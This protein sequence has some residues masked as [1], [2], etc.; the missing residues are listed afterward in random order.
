M[1]AVSRPIGPEQTVLAQSLDQ[2][3]T[4]D[5]RRSAWPWVALL[6]AGVLYGSWIPFD[7]SLSRAGDALRH[8][9]PPLGF[10]RSSMDDVL[11]NIAVYVP[12]GIALF[13]AVGRRGRSA[14][15]RLFMAV[16][17]ATM[18]SFIAES[19]QVLCASRVPSW[20][21]VMVNG[22]GA[23]LGALIAP[24][25]AAGARAGLRRFRDAIETQPMMVAASVLSILWMGLCLAPFRF[26]PNTV[27]L[28]DRFL[29]ARW[30][31][32]PKGLSNAA[33]II[34]ALQSAAPLMIA[35]A[36]LALG[37]VAQ[38]WSVAHAAMSAVKHALVLSVAVEVMR[39]FTV[40]DAFDL[41]RI[42]VA[43]SAAALAV[44]LSFVPFG[45]VRRGSAAPCDLRINRGFFPT[46]ALL[47]LAY[48]IVGLDR[49]ISSGA[50]L[51]SF[52]SPRLAL[53]FESLWR[54]STMNAAGQMLA[55]AAKSGL[56]AMVLMALIGG[57][58][59]AKLPALVAV[60][61]ALWV[62][63]IQLSGSAARGAAFDLTGPMLAWVTAVIA[64]RTYLTLRPQ[65]A[66]RA[67]VG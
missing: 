7:M 58:R 2:A 21:D 61:T 47:G 51:E 18:V 43:V 35:C 23:T 33:S 49:L 42:P 50:G 3:P 40:T 10:P 13:L 24:L 48:A 45:T 17:L 8:K 29:L 11:V 30:T 5:V 6:T 60:A 59:A 39:T 64:I 38:R 34:T 55:T 62:A 15:A 1:D 19:G 44:G 20:I 14:V 37:R 57:Q 22:C 65:L 31:L 12:L 28:H 26:V 67:P 32:L 25:V 56:L 53:P 46:L 52:L 63:A 9:F 41:S 66:R 16:N 4:A 27:E 54:T 36:C